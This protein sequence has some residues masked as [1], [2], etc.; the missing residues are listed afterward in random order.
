MIWLPKSIMH[1]RGVAGGKVGQTQ[2]LSEDRQGEFQYTIGPYSNRVLQIEPGDRI[3][4]ETIDTFG[5]AIR[6]EVDLP[7]Q[8]LCAPFLNPQS[9][10]IVGGGA[11]KGDVLAVHIES[12]VPRRQNPRGTVC[13]IPNFGGLTGTHYTATLNEPLPE[14]VK[15]VNVDETSVYWGTRLL[16]HIAPILG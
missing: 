2:E 5:G 12:I 14:R 4:V 1:T 7:T 9:G 10:P 11:T 13:M 8:K 6:T 16:Y 15:K 3:I